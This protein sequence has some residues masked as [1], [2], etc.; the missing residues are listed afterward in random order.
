MTKA[1]VELFQ[2]FLSYVLELEFA[3]DK[4]NADIK[5]IANSVVCFPFA[6]LQS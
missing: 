5:N 3:L 6:S 1:F 4:I 2:A